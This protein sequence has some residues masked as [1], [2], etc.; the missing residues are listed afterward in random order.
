M[1]SRTEMRIRNNR[2]EVCGNNAVQFQSCE[3]NS[4]CT[5]LGE[6]GCTDISPANCEIRT[7]IRFM[8]VKKQSPKDIYF[9]ANC[10]TCMD[11]TL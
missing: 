7:V 8:H 10:A 3:G 9:T 11:P 4:Y 6:N 5:G 1:T 2:K